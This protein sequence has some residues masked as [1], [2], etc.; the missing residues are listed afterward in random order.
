MRLMMFCLLS[1]A[2]CAGTGATR[3]D[4]ETS[5][6]A[7]AETAFAQSM[8]DR[9]FEAFASFI[10]DDAVFVNGGD[11]LRGKDRILAHWKTYFE[12]SDAPFSWHPETAEIGGGDLGY[13]EGPVLDPSGVVFARFHS[14]W[15]L[16]P[17]GGWLLIFDNGQRVCA[18]GE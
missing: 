7:L 6:L 9:D 13:T 5:Q 10:A 1:L 14:I 15:R 12:A 11:P 16:Q 8:S 18:T 2:G 3:T 4:F 17:G